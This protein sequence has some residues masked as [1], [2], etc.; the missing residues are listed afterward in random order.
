MQKYPRVNNYPNIHRRYANFDNFDWNNSIVILGCSMVFGQGVTMEQT[1]A[2][3]LE[4]LTNIPCINLG[5][6]GASPMY[7]W[8]ELADIL[9]MGIKPKA[10]VVIW[11]NTSRFI[12][13]LGNDVKN[14]TVSSLTMPEVNITTLAKEWIIHDHQGFEFTKRAI[15]SSR[16]MC[17]DIPYFE[18]SWFH[19]KELGLF[20]LSI[21]NCDEG[22]DNW[23]PGPITYRKWA[24]HIAND[25]KVS[26]KV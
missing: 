18:Y 17:K 7:I 12:E 10:I 13:Y 22:S 1:V 15:M 4:L 19:N 23:H 20:N 14:Y 2:H 26:K 9:D 25:I 6:Q 21:Y 16:V 11:S 8:S 24:E 5:V 3:Q